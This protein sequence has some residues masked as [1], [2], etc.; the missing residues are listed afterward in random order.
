MQRAIPIDTRLLFKPLHHELVKLLKSLNE[1]DWQKATVAKKWQ[2]KDVA[3]HIL[4]GQLRVLSIQRDQF[5]GEKPPQIKHQEELVAWLNALNA[6]W[7]RASRRL[8]PKVLVL[9]LETIGNLVAEYFAGLDP[10]DEAI[11]PV[12]WAGESSSFNWMHIAR[13]YTEY[14]HHQ[15]QIRQAVGKTGM[16]SKEFFRPVMETFFQALPHTFKGVEAEEGTI[17]E[18]K[19]TSEAGGS[20]FLVKTAEGW[21]LQTERESMPTAYVEIPIDLSWVLFSKSIRPHEVMDQIQMHG[22]TALARKV[23]DMVSVMA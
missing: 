14:W 19:I 9:L 4:D 10:W 12:A 21:K 2:V 8:S 7:V 5:Y 22:D 18:A 17:V 6:D 20:W 13:E 23:L 15:Q 16:M 3:S 11:F 1:E